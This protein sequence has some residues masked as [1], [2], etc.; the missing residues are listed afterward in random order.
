MHVTTLLGSAR[1]KGNTATVLG[2]AEAELTHRGHT[3]ERVHLHGQ[4]IA[5]CLG[6]GKCKEAPDRIGCVQQDDATAILEKM[7]AADAVL[8]A[9]PIYFWGFASQIKRLIDRTYALVTNY[10]RP[11][12]ASLMEHK[13]IGLLVT[14]ADDYANNAEGL[15]TAFDR[16]ADFLLAVR[17]GAL[18]VGGCTTPTDLPTRVREQAADLARALVG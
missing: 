1:K 15:F 13:P 12:H 16:I 3:V 8:F 10:H 18:Y 7:I 11:G 9:S 2:W 6:C 17:A 5:G 14:G 4:A